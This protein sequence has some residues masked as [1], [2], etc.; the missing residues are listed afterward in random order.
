MALVVTILGVR[1][2]WDALIA[3]TAR[4]AVNA[5]VAGRRNLAE[6][7]RKAGAWAVARFGPGHNYMVPWS[8]LVY[9]LDGYWTA[10]PVAPLAEAL[11]YG[12]AHGAEYLVEEMAQEVPSDQALAASTPFGLELAAVYRSES[13]P[14][15]VAFYR[16]R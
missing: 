1:F 13:S 5:E 16:L 4:P 9:W 3:T 7:A 14:Y 10:L 6:E 8:R 2:Q 11:A 15:A 12:R